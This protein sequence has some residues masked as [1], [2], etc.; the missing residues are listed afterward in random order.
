MRSG[1][2]RDPLTD[3]YNRRHL[4]ISLQ[5]ELARALRHGFPVSL[6]MLDVDHFKTFNDTNGHDAGDEVL[7]NVAHVLK[8]HTRAEDVACR[9]GGEEFLVVLPACPV[10]DAY[11]KA[12]AIREAIAQLHVFSRGIALPRVT[13]SLGIACYPEDGERMEDLIAEADAALYR[14]KSSGRNCIAASN[15]PGD[16]VLF[17]PRPR[18]PAESPAEPRPGAKMTA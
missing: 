2:E 4:E 10:D 9:Y 14:A 12:E 11:A 15:A 7:R 8:R 17:E 5:R 16:I 3:L 13:A 1:S 18:E 6:L